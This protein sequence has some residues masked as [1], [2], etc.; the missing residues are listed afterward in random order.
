MSEPLPVFQ[1]E[2]FMKQL[3]RFPLRE[4][5]KIVDKLKHITNEDIRR[6]PYL[7]GSYKHLKKYR[8]G[9]Y[10]IFMAY[11]AECYNKYREKIN[12]NDCEED[13]LEKIV[14]FSI[15]SRPKLYKRMNR[16][17]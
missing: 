15:D 7:K 2:V 17:R 10:R 4:R 5:D 11:C 8:T 16:R 14:V 13:N 3:Q 1:H 6:V 12:C 9:D